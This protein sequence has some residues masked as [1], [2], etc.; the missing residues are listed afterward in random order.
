MIAVTQTEFRN[1]IK[2]YLDA[3]ARGETLRVSR[4]GKPFAEVSPL[5]TDGEPSWK[6][7]EPLI[8]LP[9]GVSASRLIL[10]ERDEGW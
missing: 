6:R 5:D 2:R 8:K 10:A 7:R 4:Y 9:K 1:N 3:V